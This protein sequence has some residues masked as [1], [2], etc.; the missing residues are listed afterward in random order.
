MRIEKTTRQ[1]I[2]KRAQE[3]PSITVN[4][5]VGMIETYCEAPDTASLVE[6]EMKRT[7]R[8]LLATLRDD[9]K[10]RTHFALGD[11]S[12]V[13]VCIDSCGRL[14]LSPNAGNQL[15]PLSCVENQLKVKRNG[16]NKSLRKVSQIK[17]ALGLC[18]DVS[19]TRSEETTA[20]AEKLYAMADELQSLLAM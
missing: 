19:G 8:K 4:E 9:K 14:E 17:K 20:L 5:I 13:Y 6:A 12:G 3:N 2:L 11:M 15:E 7:A 1:A 18:V 16:L 10:E